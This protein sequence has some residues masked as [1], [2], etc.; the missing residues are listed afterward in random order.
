MLTVAVEALHQRILDALG[1]DV[2]IGT[3]FGATTLQVAVLTSVPEAQAVE[4]LCDVTMHWSVSLPRHDNVEN[5]SNCLQL[6]KRRRS[7]S[8]MQQVELVSVLDVF[9][10]SAHFVHGQHIQFQNF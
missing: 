5:R 2:R 3:T 8:Q 1:C 9:V 10:A 7:L 4:A 6:R